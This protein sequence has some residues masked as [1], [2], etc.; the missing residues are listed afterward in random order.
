MSTLRVNNMTNVGG[1]GPTYAPGHV[2]Q[3]QTATAST[4]IQS[5]SSSWVSTGLAVSITPKSSNSKI[6]IITQFPSV[7][8]PTNIAAIYT[9]FRGDVS[10]GT[11][12]G[13][14]ASSNPGL[15]QLYTPYGEIRTSYSM[16]MVDSPATTG[17]L[18]YT[19]AFNAVGGN[20]TV[21]AENRRGTITV[22]EVAA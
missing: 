8:I 19:A 4:S 1:I 14:S 13:T 9:I 10:T 3:V 11:N 20:S 6:I 18:T 22:M 5:T 2:I 12:L 17:S 15:G 16:T 7:N 21:M